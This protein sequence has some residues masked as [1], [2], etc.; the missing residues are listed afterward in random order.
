MIKNPEM[1]V[2]FALLVAAG[3]AAPQQVSTPAPA[4]AQSAT[5]PPPPATPVL[6]LKLDELERRPA[7]TFTPKDGG[8]KQDAAPS[9]PGLGG[10]P[11]KSWEDP[12]STVVPKSSNY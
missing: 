5:Q 3:A 6:N 12:P 4:P 9:L 10:N 2:A 1:L 11:S 8:K 7:I